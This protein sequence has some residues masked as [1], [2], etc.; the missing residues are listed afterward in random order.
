M[1]STINVLSYMHNLQMAQ[2]TKCLHYLELDEEGEVEISTCL[3][4]VDMKLS[5][6]KCNLNI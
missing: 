6:P 5:L 2:G 3:V 4:H 1:P